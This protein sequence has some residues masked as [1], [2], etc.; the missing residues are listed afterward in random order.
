M[1]NINFTHKF[2]WKAFHC[3]LLIFRNVKPSNETMKYM[4]NV[5]TRD[6][7]DITILDPCVHIYLKFESLYEEGVNRTLKS[8]RLL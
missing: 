4:N 7:V 5:D 8:L 3:L 6:I 2:L 1:Q